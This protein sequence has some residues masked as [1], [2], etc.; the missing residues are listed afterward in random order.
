M[1][2]MSQTHTNLLSISVTDQVIQPLL[3]LL[4]I[5]SLSSFLSMFLLG[6][7]TQ[8]VS[9]VYIQC[10]EWLDRRKTEFLPIF[11]KK[12]KKTKTFIYIRISFLCC[13]DRIGKLRSI[14]MQMYGFKFGRWLCFNAFLCAPYFMLNEIYA[15]LA[16]VKQTHH[17]NGS[18]RQ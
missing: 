17:E 15:K 8:T 14:S 11:E 18:K 12:K 10:D 4:L 16:Y 2:S 1:F 5:F 13:F 3:L 6:K 7:K 9:F